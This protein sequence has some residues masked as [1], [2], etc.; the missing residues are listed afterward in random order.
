MG[1]A[2]GSDQQI[3]DTVEVGQRMEKLREIKFGNFIG[4][5]EKTKIRDEMRSKK[6]KEKMEKKEKEKQHACF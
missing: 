6:K 1:I 3:V 2:A 5:G 4:V